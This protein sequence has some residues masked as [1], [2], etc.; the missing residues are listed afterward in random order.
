MRRIEE[1]KRESEK[2]KS[3]ERGKAA[4]KIQ[5]LARG[6]IGRRRYRRDLPGLKKRKKVGAYCVECEI[7]P[8]TRR[9][10]N[11]RDRYCVECYERIHAKGH[12]KDHS[13]ENI[14]VDARLMV[15]NLDDTNPDGTK[16]KRKKGYQ[17]KGI[18]EEDNSTIST[19]RTKT[20]NKKDWEEF[21]DQA[22]K[23]KYWY[24]KVT[25]EASWIS[26]F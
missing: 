9:C 22:A 18:I 7:R 14:I 1:H 2:V 3:D 25:G 10:R 21:F 5:A 16:K 24:N 13:W 20:V 11:C 23:A 17:A 12:R 6:V 4:L 26:P 15:M 8:A 19:T